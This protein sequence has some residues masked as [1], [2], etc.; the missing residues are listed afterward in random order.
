[1]R[2]YWKTAD[3]AEGRTKGCLGAICGSSRRGWESL[4]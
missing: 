1:M 2:C 3:S 4:L